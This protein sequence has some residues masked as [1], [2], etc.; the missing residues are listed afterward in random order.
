MLADHDITHV[1]FGL[2]TSL[3]EESLL[4]TWTIRGTDITWKQIYEYAFNK[5]GVPPPKKIVSKFHV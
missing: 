4:D 3:E 1:I 2:G 5:E